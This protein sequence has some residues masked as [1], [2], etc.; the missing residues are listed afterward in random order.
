MVRDSR[1]DTQKEAVTEED[2]ERHLNKGVFV[3]F[4]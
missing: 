2:R 3:K 4:K 1:T